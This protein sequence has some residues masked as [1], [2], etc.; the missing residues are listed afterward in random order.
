M[1]RY[2]TI[3]FLFDLTK[4]EYERAQARLALV[5]TKAQ[6]IAL[7]V[8]IFAGLLATF[9]D[10]IRLSTPADGLLLV[11]TILSLAYALVLALSASLL[12]EVPSPRSAAELA[13]ELE[14]QMGSTSADNS[15]SVEDSIGNTM[16]SY[17]RA[18]REL[19][20]LL[21]ERT[22]RVRNAQ[23]ALL[24]ATLLVFVWLGMPIIGTGIGLFNK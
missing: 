20:G 1:T 19:G 21:I 8:G 10:R 5:E 3:R 14:E 11:G 2:E 15:R 23:I 9:G 22:R 7:I 6:M 16:G 24:F 18:S 4:D 12:V 17:V 13:D